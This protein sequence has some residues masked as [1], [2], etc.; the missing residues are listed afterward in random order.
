MEM[1]EAVRAEVSIGR[2]A[3]L[4]ESGRTG[5]ALELLE[6]GANALGVEWSRSFTASAFDTAS[7]IKR[8]VPVM[9]FDFDQT[10]YGAVEAMRRN[11]LRLIREFTNKQRQATRQAL[12]AGVEQ[13]LNP[14]E[15]AR[16]FR[17]SIGLTA[18][19]EQIVRN[20]RRDLEDGS[21]N[22]L[23]RELRDRR[24]D[25]AA[26]RAVDGQKLP[27]GQI[28]KMVERYRQRMI[29][30]RA[31]T[32]A[33]T[34]SLR[35]VHEGAL[36]TYKQAVEEGVVEEDQ[37]KR[38]WNSASDS[39]VRHSHRTMDGQQRALDE[40]FVSGNGAKLMY[41]T[42]PSGPADDTINC[43]CVVA[44]TMDLENADT[45]G[46]RVRIEGL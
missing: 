30:Q 29:S 32:I 4:L 46:V 22:A 19:Q 21:A 6:A 5:E 1:I 26:R 11:R 38:V 17:D 34:E 12:A 16:L 28:D 18:Y 25:G 37:L 44:V 35:A 23:S 24:F 20:Y 9:D 27:K 14:R 7:H 36:A 15:Q 39:R 31:E 13:G 40:P 43:R 8:H 3:S 42:D 10:N 45:S 33:R 41:P 2:I